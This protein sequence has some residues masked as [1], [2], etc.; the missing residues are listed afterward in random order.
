MD[1]DYKTST[2]NTNKLLE[3]NKNINDKNYNLEMEKLSITAQL[4]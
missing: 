4:N 3:F 1:Y 2:E